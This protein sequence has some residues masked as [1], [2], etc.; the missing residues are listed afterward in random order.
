MRLSAHILS[1]DPSV[2]SQKL[3]TQLQTRHDDHHL[4]IP[5]TQATQPVQYAWPCK[6]FFSVFE[7]KVLKWALGG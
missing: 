7:F 5:S 3:T 4:N 6:Y 1:Q 2:Y